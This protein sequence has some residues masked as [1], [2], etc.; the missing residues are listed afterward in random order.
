MTTT[1]EDNALHTELQELY[2]ITKQW[3][4]DLKFISDETD[5]LKKL[6]H[7]PLEPEIKEK[8]AVL[9]NTLEQQHSKLKLQV[10]HLLK[11]LA[12]LTYEPIKEIKLSLIEEH[13]LLKREME[14]IML[15]FHAT[16]NKLLTHIPGK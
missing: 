12:P 16:K 9:F 11:K 5:I 3:S 1:I 7:Q 2:L 4:A 14:E 10:V 8:H 13:Q 15:A 6:T